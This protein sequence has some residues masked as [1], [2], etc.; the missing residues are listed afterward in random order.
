MWWLERRDLDGL[1]IA[2]GIYL[3][4]VLAIVV[5]GSLRMVQ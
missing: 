1:T 5:I 4:I 2:I 3:L